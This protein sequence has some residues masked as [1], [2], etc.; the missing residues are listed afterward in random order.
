LVNISYLR[1]DILISL[2]LSGIALLLLASPLLPL[3]NLLLQPVQA[4][5][6]VT[7]QPSP[8]TVQNGQYALTFEAKGTACSSYCRDGEVTSGTFQLNSSE[9]VV[10][11]GPLD[12]HSSSFTNDS[13]GVTINLDY[14]GNK[15]AADSSYLIV[16]SC[17]TSDG[18]DI[19]VTTPNLNLETDFYDPVECI[20]RGGEGE[21]H[22]T[23]PT[24]SSPVTGTTTTTTQQDSDGDGIPDSSDKCAHNSNLRCFKEGDISNTTTTSSTT[25]QQQQPS[26]SNRTGNQTR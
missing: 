8:T 12:A 24:S 26:S 11:E 17:S 13:S 4:Q 25:Q 7:F 5:S 16:T 18:N 2:A 20:I 15:D 10:D 6:T 21:A 14:L 1:N 23:Q 9:G 3:S 19:S 22:S